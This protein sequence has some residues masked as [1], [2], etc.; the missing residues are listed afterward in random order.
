MAAPKDKWPLLKARYIEH[1]SVLG[2]SKRSVET[3]ETHL[4]FFLEYL[5]SET[6]IPDLSEIGRADLN[7]YQTWLYFSGWRKDPERPL[8]LAS[9]ASRLSV[10]KGFFRWLLQ[11]GLVLHDAAASMD[12]PKRPKALPRAILGGPQVVKLLKAPNVETPVGLRDRAILELLYATGLRNEE[13]R[14]L[15]LNDVDREGCQARVTGKGSK[16]RVVPVGRIALNWLDLYLETAR[17]ALLLGPENGFVF[18]SCKGR[19]IHSSNLI[20]M[21]RKYARRA[22]LPANVTPHALRHTCATHLLKAG[23]DIRH[24]QALLGHS[25]LDSTQIYTRVEIEDLKKVHRTFH[26]REHTS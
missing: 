6:K 17:P 15:K 7:A 13:L 9:Q 11:E 2:Y 1:L 14:N 21:I 26:P 19:K 12:R 8:C 5:E 10:V 22:R 3:T 24:I 16:E 25:S 4:R 20:A 23:A 18:V